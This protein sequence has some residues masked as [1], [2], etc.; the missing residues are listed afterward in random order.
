MAK[1]TLDWLALQIIAVFAERG[2]NAAYIED[3]QKTLTGRDRLS[4][5]LWC[6][7]LDSDNKAALANRLHV[8]ETDL[9]TTLRTLQKI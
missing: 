5:L 8:N 9:A 3:T 7:N 2:L 1:K 4:V 6:N